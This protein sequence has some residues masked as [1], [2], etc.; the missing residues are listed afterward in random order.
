VDNNNFS[1][2]KKEWLIINDNHF[3]IA[4]ITS[5]SEL[6]CYEMLDH[7]FIEYEMIVDGKEVIF[8]HHIP[9]IRTY[10]YKWKITT[11]LLLSRKVADTQRVNDIK[12]Q[13]SD[14]R[15]KTIDLI[16]TKV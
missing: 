5:V 1:V 4:A 13:L 9:F 15:Q 8:K 3:K 10:D 12:K 6:K 2:W 16:R 11:P 7:T 14:M